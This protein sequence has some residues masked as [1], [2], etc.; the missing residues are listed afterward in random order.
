MATKENTSST[1]QQ[2]IEGAL[3]CL[4]ALRIMV[5]SATKEYD[6]SLESFMRREVDDTKALAEAIGPMPTFLEGVVLTLAEYIHS[7]QTCGTPSLDKWKPQVAMT[8]SERRAELAEHE[9]LLEE[10]NV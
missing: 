5:D 10:F 7:G 1:E 3:A 6:G 8:E 9:A 4:A 2:R